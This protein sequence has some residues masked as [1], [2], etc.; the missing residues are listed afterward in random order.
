MTPQ[1]QYKIDLEKW[2]VDIA[3][4]EKAEKDWTESVIKLSKNRL[5][6]PGPA[7]RPPAPPVVDRSK[8]KDLLLLGS[9]NQPHKPISPPSSGMPRPI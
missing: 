8:L 3:A 7:P 6:K 4:W 9:G 5:T 1:E 2:T